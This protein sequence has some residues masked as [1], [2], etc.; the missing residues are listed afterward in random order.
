MNRIVRG[1]AAGLVGAAFAAGAGSA[2]ETVLRADTSGQGSVPAIMMVTLGEVLQDQTPY[3]LQIST[4][5]AGTRSAVDGA[6]GNVDVF[7]S[8]PTITHYMKTQTLMF[9][10]MDDAPE[11][12]THIRSIVNY[13]FGAY[14]AVTWADS[15]IESLKDVKGKR[16]FVGPPGGAAV[17]S[18][19]SMIEAETG[20]KMGEDYDTAKLDWNA[21]FQAFQDRQVDVYFMP[22]AAPA[23]QFQQ[24]AAM[25][26]IR[27]LGL[28]DEAANSDLIKEVISV[29]GR[30]IEELPPGIY[31]PNQVNETP[32]KTLGTWGVL[33]VGAH[34]DEETAYQITKAF[35]DNIDRF[36]EASVP[37]KSIT[38]ETGIKYL[39]SPLHPGA[40]RYYKEAGF[41]IPPGAVPPEVSQ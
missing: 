12:A 32:V 21:G 5:K 33:D 9:A 22:S 41:D 14:H 7:S 3:R 10:K 4:G 17:R 2:Q 19:V 6:K 34:V 26:E 16:L 15:G 38:R 29:V 25:G 36:H 28:S 13:P 30:T 20:Y 39:A 31:G 8:A 11:L 23:A 40:Y 24:L 27:F 1:F 37:L 18:S 35:W